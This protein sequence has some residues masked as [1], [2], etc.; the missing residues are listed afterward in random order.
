MRE[1][2]GISC[3]NELDPIN[4]SGA[5]FF[6]SFCRINKLG[7][8][9]LHAHYETE[10][11]LI[12]KGEA[13]AIVEDEEVFLAQ[14][15]QLLIH[16]F[17]KHIIK[18][19]GHEPLE[20][21][22]VYSRVNTKN[23]T[24]QNN[25]LIISAPPTPNGDLHIGHI[26]GPYLSADV[27][28]RFLMLRG[29]KV[30]HFSATDDHQTYIYKMAKD[31][32]K[33]EEKISQKYHELIITDFVQASIQVDDFLSPANDDNYKNFIKRKFEKLKKSDAVSSKEVEFPF[34]DGF[35]YEAFLEGT[36][37]KCQ[38]K[39]TGQCCESCG[40]VGAASDFNKS[41]LKPHQCLTLELNQF[42]EFLKKY[43]NSLNLQ[44]EVAKRAKEWR[45]NLGFFTLNYPEDIGIDGI[46]VWCEMAFGML[47][48]IKKYSD[49]VDDLIYCFGIDNSYYYLILIPSILKALG[50]E[51]K[52]PTKVIINEFYY[53][54]GEK[55]STSKEHAVWV[56]D[57]HKLKWDN[58]RFFLALS[59]SERKIGNYNH[60]EFLMFSNN[61][62]LKLNKVK[63]FEKSGEKHRGF[64]L[65]GDG[66]NFYRKLIRKILALE[67]SMSEDFSLNIYASDALEVLDDYL[68]YIEF[69]EDKL[70]E[71]KIF[72]PLIKMALYPILPNTFDPSEF[73]STWNI[74]LRRNSH[75]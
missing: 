15:D 43:H 59:R 64:T 46:H 75:E 66:L 24:K 1:A 63:S 39:I 17:E 71:K 12:T 27:L 16:P 49:K 30:K 58:L 40:F 33:G 6:P 18:N 5:S 26:S 37:P 36:C 67:N 44:G 2:Y 61:L 60:N 9:F 38:G 20:F 50:E 53:L 41:N 68:S 45:D 51:E 29:K 56:K 21:F 14:N 31:Y 55:F 13:L 65:G 8:T 19:V 70:E 10:I 34:L 73:D 72:I 52:L 42:R 74:D 35:R 57:I 62:T 48:Q 32:A 28:K 22:S 23:D 7:E 3:L 11:F 69:S 4:S 25:S 47:Y 54:D